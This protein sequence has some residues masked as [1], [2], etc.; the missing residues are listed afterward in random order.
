[1]DEVLEMCARVESGSTGET[2]GGV[3]RKKGGRERSAEL[4]M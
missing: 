3:G 2:C 1:M 4:C